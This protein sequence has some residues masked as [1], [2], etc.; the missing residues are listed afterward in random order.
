M[1][2]TI[3]ARS[4]SR[5]QKER[6]LRSL[7]EDDFRDLV[8]R[9]LFF[10]LG[11]GDGS[12]T[13]GP[14]EQ[15]KDALFTE[16]D[17]LGLLHVVAV[18]TKAG[19]LNLASKASANLLTAVTQLRTALQT[20]VVRLNTKSSC[21]PSKVYLC[22]SGRINDSAKDHILANIKDSRIHFLDINELI[23]RIDDRYPE[24]W[25][26]IDAEILPY[27]RAIKAFVEG[28]QEK[29][30]GVL[31][32]PDILIGS[33]TD[34]GFV[35][36]S[37]FRAT[38]KTRKV[39]GKL[40]VEPDFEEFPVTALLSKRYT[41]SMILADAGMG[42][43]TALHRMAYL[44]AEKG[45][46]SKTNYQIPI[47]IRATDIFEN[48]SSP[49]QHTADH[50]AKRLAGTSKSI[51]TAVDLLE[52]RV[53][54][55]IDALDEISNKE[56][57]AAVLQL[58]EEFAKSYPKCRVIATGRP[59]R[60]L[61][62]LPNYE[63]FSISPISWRQAEKIV[64]SIE[65][66]KKLP[67]EQSKEVLRRLEQIHG[68]ELN[69]LLVAVFAATS[70]YSRQDIP[71]NITELFKKFT[72]LM[73]GRWDEQKGLSLQYQAPLKDFL[74]KHV[75]FHMH[76][77]RN[78]SISTAR[79]E[80]IIGHELKIR[81]YSAN[82]PNFLEELLHRSGLFRLLGDQIEFR[83]HLLQEF[84]AGRGIPSVDFIKRI[85]TDEWWKRAIVFYFGE[86]P[87]DVQVLKDV[88]AS[89]PRIS[90]QKVYEATTTVGLALQAC[91]LS[92]VSEKIDIWKSIVTMLALTDGGVLS[93]AKDEEK[94]PLSMFI[95]Y[96]LYGR[97]SVAL[98]NV[99]DELTKLA[100]WAKAQRDSLESKGEQEAR[101]FW[102]MVALIEL[103][104]LEQARELAHNY[105]P[106]Q[107][108]YLLA[109]FLGSRL[110]EEVR[111]STAT[112]KREAQK[113]GKGLESRISPL[114]GKLRAEFNSQLL[115][116]RKGKIEVVEPEN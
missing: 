39:R 62:G 26:G 45:V 108:L 78:T 5:F 15:G 69:P 38:T 109:L 54:I 9:P 1:S 44:I 72:E 46:V 17:N 16:M 12:D 29:H 31:S 57:R 91:Y 112:Q 88:F 24:L 43:T 7:S 35:S 96:Y 48:I 60:D 6:Y 52:G 114:L 77:G 107:G 63:I 66:G 104:C 103:G 71:A 74:L 23:P 30:T 20:S 87:G 11:F 64:R 89:I 37:L 47:I 81:G 19:N 73:L 13:C 102:F 68:F 21:L 92:E 22:A 101:L 90:E 53:L 55:L 82:L 79:F 36:L 49:L 8:I 94:Y 18:Q 80:E 61:T 105:T 97:D 67:A 116:Y 100:A 51:F 95:G 76:E 2:N 10:R 59:Y 93:S 41:H 86:N 42:K 65:K 25:F 40:V 110:T 28:R 27:F 32:R 58:V 113:L 75:A 83:H 70:E 3:D 50:V 98:A 115:E 34:A 84:F 106:S 14:T 85:V 33:A 99:K 56:G 4:I 111:S